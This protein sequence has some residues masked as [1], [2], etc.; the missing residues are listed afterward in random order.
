MSEPE[1]HGATAVGTVLDGS[2]RLTRLI[3][4][5]GMGAVFEAVQ[6]RLGKRVA[7]KVMA[8][9]LI[10]NDEALARFRREVEITSQL[11]HPHVIQVSDFGTSPSGEPYLV[12]EYLEGEDLE[13]RIERVSR[14]SLPTVAHVVK[15]LAS[16]LAATHAKGVVHRDLKPANVFLVQIP[17]DADFVKVVDFGISKIV[18]RSSTKLTGASVVMGTP[19]YMSPEQ[20]AGKVDKIDHRTDQWA[21]ACITW[22]MLSG[23]QPFIAPD[24]NALLYQIINGNL[25]PLAAKVPG[26]PDDVEEVLRRA[27]SKR[28]QDR[29]PTITAFARAFEGA[30]AATPAAKPPEVHRRDKDKEKGT[31]KDRDRDRDRAK[32]KR[33]ASGPFENVSKLVKNI[34]QRATSVW[35]PAKEKQRRATRRKKIAWI[36]AAVGGTL[37][38]TSAVVLYSGRLPW[39]GSSASLSPASG[40][41]A[42]T[43]PASPTVVP[44]R[45]DKGNGNK[46]TEPRKRRSPLR[47]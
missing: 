21:M 28:Q 34:S 38:I 36:S 17:G 47:R 15:Q 5:G 20:A 30:A 29:F 1:Q 7:V 40:Q 10:A 35:S 44:L 11:A 43:S 39:K 3:G 46:S 25:P 23:R 6:M 13:T 12:M 24:V 4:A 32:P 26:L 14:L 19:E 42:A 31:D 2:Y 41:Q 27:L 16:A 22:Q 33:R 9:G 18:R 8:R 45:S 37:L